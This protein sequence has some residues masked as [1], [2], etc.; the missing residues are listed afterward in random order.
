MSR[1]AI[2][3]AGLCALAI[4]ASGCGGG[5][6]A[7]AESP[8]D[9]TKLRAEFK[10]R[11]G[12]Q[13]N[14]APWYRHITA[15]NWANGKLEITTDLSPEEYEGSDRLRGAICGE[16]LKLAFEQQVEPDT[17]D[18]IAAVFGAGGVGLGYCG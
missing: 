7:E 13:D 4:A 14:E 17:I 16:P 6:N 5:S 2:A 18:L 15:I 10:E 3:V 9:I 12:T 11:F 1:K 8:V